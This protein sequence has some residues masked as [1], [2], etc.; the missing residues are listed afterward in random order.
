MRKVNK[1]RKQK[2]GLEKIVAQSAFNLGATIRKKLY[3]K[4]F[5][6]KM[7]FKHITTKYSKIMKKQKMNK[8]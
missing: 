7:K 4:N 6:S 5:H 2:V 8:I 3:L 1:K